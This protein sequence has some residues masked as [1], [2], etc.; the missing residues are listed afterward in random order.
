MLLLY[1]IFT[2]INIPEVKTNIYSSQD[3][4]EIDTWR[5]HK[6]KVHQIIYTKL[7]ELQYYRS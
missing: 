7:L 4:I 3:K 1:K 6:I 2:K 5:I